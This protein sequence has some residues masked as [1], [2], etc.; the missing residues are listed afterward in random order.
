MPGLIAGHFQVQCCAGQKRQP[1]A[2]AESVATKCEPLRDSFPPAR[3]RSAR[4]GDSWRDRRYRSRRTDEASGS[5]PR[6]RGVPRCEGPIDQKRLGQSSR[7]VNAELSVP[8]LARESQVGIESRMGHADFSICCGHGPLR[9]GNVRPA[10]QQLRWHANWNRRR[11][12]RQRPDRN[13]K[14]GSLLAHQ[15]GDRMFI[16]RAQHLKIGSVRFGSL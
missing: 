10:L 5:E 4:S 9:R 12:S 2:A 13:G 1:V 14:I 3:R 7:W 8:P 15:D 16:L 11:R 6:Q